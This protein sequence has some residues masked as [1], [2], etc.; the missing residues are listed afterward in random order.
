MLTVS[1]TQKGFTLIELMVVVGIIGI[2]VMI[3]APK[4]EQ[5]QSK[6]KASEAKLLLAGAFQF[7]K[8]YYAEHL[9][10]TSCLAG[11]G[12]IPEGSRR[13]YSIGFETV[14]A[15]SNNCGA[16]VTSSCLGVSWNSDGSAASSCASGL[17]STYYRANSGIS[18]GSSVCPYASD[19]NLA[20]TPLNTYQFAV[21]AAGCISKKTNAVDRWTIDQNKTLL[22]IT[23]GY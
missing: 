14:A 21:E 18:N 9:T 13:W 4:F 23:L 19:L 8:S 6:A 20:N 1:K 10:Y 15:S 3:A 17:N 7:E 2:L 22:N 11:I 16:S 5:Y 12:F